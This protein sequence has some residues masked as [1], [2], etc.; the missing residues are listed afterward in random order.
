MSSRIGGESQFY[1]PGGGLGVVVSSRL[2]GEF[3]HLLTWS[4]ANHNL[5]K[6]N[7][8]NV[9][10]SLAPGRGATVPFSHG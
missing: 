1:L 2:G 6:I 7:Y 3:E 8:T 4:L 9:P 5:H 10:Q